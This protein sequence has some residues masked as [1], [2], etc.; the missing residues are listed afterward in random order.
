M[1]AALDHRGALQAEIDSARSEVDDAAQHMGRQMPD[2]GLRDL[3]IRAEVLRKAVAACELLGN[4]PG[5]KP[6]STAVRKTLPNPFTLLSSD[7]KEPG[8]GRL[9]PGLLSEAAQK[10]W[11]PVHDE[12]LRLV[13]NLTLGETWALRF[14][15][16]PGAG[17]PQQ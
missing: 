9:H 3:L 12:A 14:V 4:L 17:Q 10:E 13:R 2:G 5:V 1:L 15:L 8:H 7:L 16:T 11:T 6:K